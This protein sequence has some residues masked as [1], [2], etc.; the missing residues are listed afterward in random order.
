MRVQ[1]LKAM[2]EK[3]KTERE[4]FEQ[5]K[6]AA[7]QPVMNKQREMEAAL[8]RE[9]ASVHAQLAQESKERASAQLAAETANLSKQKAELD[10]GYA[11]AMPNVST[12]FPTGIVTSTL[13]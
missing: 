3:L 7:E 4:Q 6:V 8:E 10:A 1:Q 13:V 2:E 5:A 9:K 12:A 11:A